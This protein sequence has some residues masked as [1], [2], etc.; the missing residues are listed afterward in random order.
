MAPA[1]SGRLLSLCKGSCRVF[2][3]ALNVS[4]GGQVGDPMTFLGY[5]LGKT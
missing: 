5:V 4:R 2:W 3:E 1:F